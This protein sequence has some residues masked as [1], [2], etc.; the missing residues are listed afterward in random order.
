MY[1]LKD[2]AFA[3][4]IN[5]LFWAK[6]PPPALAQALGRFHTDFAMV[7]REFSVE[8]VRNASGPA[9]GCLPAALPDLS[10][11]SIRPGHTLWQPSTQQCRKSA[12][13]FETVQWDGETVQRRRS[14]GSSATSG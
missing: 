10:A 7:R 2:T 13:G 3:L 11:L 8:P 14:T 6:T 9:N 5:C 4:C 12:A 1:Q